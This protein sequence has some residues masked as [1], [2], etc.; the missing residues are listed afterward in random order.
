VL[1]AEVR[2]L[3]EQEA[4]TMANEHTSLPWT[5]NLEEL[6]EFA[7]DGIV[8]R[9]LVNIPRAKTVLFSMSKGQSLSEHTASVPA[10]IHVLEGTA[11]IL[12][13]SDEYKA[14]PGWYGF[15]PANLAHTVNADEDLVFL[16]VMFKES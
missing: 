12:L 5:G 7:E 4:R 1:D 9:T 15:L 6:S 16:L 14:S 13:G 8:S 10:S 3:N 2:C 11:T